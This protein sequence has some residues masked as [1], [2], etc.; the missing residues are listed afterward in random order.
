MLVNWNFHIVSEFEAD[1]STN[2][3]SD[4]SPLGMALVG[5]KN[6]MRRLNSLPP[7]GKLTYK[8]YGYCLGTLLKSIMS[9]LQDLRNIR[10]EKN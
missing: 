7:I 5:K 2:K 6:C 8:N 4:H 1:P 9:T 3:I 10:L